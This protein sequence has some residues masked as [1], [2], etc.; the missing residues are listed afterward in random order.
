MVFMCEARRGVQNNGIGSFAV[1]TRYSSRSVAQPILRGCTGAC[2]GGGRD[3]N[4][5]CEFN[6]RMG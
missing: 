5:V 6:M 1:R 3:G 4:H 2:V